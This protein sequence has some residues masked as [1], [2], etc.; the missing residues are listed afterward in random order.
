MKLVN[1]KTG[2]IEKLVGYVKT[3]NDRMFFRFE[4]D[5]GTYKKEY[6]SLAELNAEWEDYE[7][8]KDHWHI[9]CNGDVFIDNTE[10]YLKSYS[11]IGNDFETA[12]EADLAIRKL[13]AWKFL[14]DMGFKIEGI[15]YRNNKNYIEWSISQKFRDDHF[16][17]DA[18]NECL[19]LLFGGNE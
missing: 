13:E 14:K 12:E 8:H 5:K 1:K 2:K 9:G 6:N 18:F 4:D 16:T 3:G 11:S 17:A 19:H 10:R 7:E 15:R